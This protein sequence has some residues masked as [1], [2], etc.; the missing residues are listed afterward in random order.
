ML[1]KIYRGT[2]TITIIEVWQ[3][4]KFKSPCIKATSQSIKKSCKIKIIGTLIICK[5]KYFNSYN[6]FCAH[7][8]Q[9]PRHTQYTRSPILKIKKCISDI[10]GVHYQNDTKNMS[11][12]P[13]HRVYPI[14]LYTWDVLE[15]STSE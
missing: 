1:V 7:D 4:K 15:L 6:R 3:D 9:T 12:N 8:E 13:R 10:Q 2:N 14:L 5:W 11:T